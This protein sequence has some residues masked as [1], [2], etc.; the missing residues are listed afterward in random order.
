MVASHLKIVVHY[1]LAD[2]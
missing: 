1:N 2:L